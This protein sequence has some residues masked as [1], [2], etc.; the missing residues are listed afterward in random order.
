M[1]YILIKVFFKR[2][3]SYLMENIKASDGNAG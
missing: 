3:F 1:S 2:H